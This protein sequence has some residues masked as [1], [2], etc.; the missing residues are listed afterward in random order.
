MNRTNPLFWPRAIP[1]CE[2]ELWAGWRKRNVVRGFLHG[3]QLSHIQPAL[4]WVKESSA[5]EVCAAGPV[6]EWIESTVMAMLRQAQQ[7]V[8]GT[9]TTSVPAAAI[10]LYINV[11]PAAGTMSS[12]HRIHG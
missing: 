11:G 1:S 9:G 12:C 5:R 4:L 3:E 10:H 8:A 2:D 6:K 7:T